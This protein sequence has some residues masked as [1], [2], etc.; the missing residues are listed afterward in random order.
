MTNYPFLIFETKKEKKNVVF[1]ED[2]QFKK[3]I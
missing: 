2:C 1:I 3:Y